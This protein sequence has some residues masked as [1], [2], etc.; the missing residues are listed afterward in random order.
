MDQHQALIVFLNLLLYCYNSFWNNYSLANKQLCNHLPDQFQVFECYYMFLNY[1]LL[2]DRKR[3]FINNNIVIFYF[4]F[5]KKVSCLCYHVALIFKK[6][7][8]KFDLIP[9]NL[10]NLSNLNIG[11]FLCFWLIF[12]P[13]NCSCKT[14]NFY[15]S[16]SLHY[17]ELKKLKLGHKVLH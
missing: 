10:D 7:K 3:L 5:R 2:A 1:F 9:E 6:T 4:Y 13:V 17:L 11:Y 15:C 8:Q 16:S 14:S 12:I